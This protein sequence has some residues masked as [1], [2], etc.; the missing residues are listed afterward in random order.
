MARAAKQPALN[1]TF[2]IAAFSLDGF[3]VLPLAMSL[4]IK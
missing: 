4:M 3:A 1:L 2:N